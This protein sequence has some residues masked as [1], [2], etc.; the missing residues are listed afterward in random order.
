MRYVFKALIMQIMYTICGLCQKTK[1]FWP[2]Y[3]F[4]ST[5]YLIY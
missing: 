1:S 2:Y 4:D 5:L 3:Y